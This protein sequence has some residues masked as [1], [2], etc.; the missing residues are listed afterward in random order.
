MLGTFI[1]WYGWFSFNFGTALLVPL[2]DVSANVGALA[3]TN[4]AIAAG[5]AATMSL[6]FNY[7]LLQRSTGSG[8]YDLQMAMNGCLAGSVSIT[9]GCAVYEPWA[10]LVTGLVAG[11]IYALGN[12]FIIRLRIDDAVDAIPVHLFAG[13]WGV[14]SVGFLASPTRQ[15]AAYGRAEHSGLLYEWSNGSFDATLLGV[16]FIGIFFIIG[17]VSTMLLPFFLWLD[18]M[19]WLRCD[20]LEEIVGLDTHEH[21]GLEHMTNQPETDDIKV[22]HFEAYKRRRQHKNAEILNKRM[23]QHNRQQSNDND[24]S[25][26]D[27]TDHNS[28]DIS[29]SRISKL[30]DTIKSFGSKL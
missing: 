3:A 17:W 16:Q 25:M 1:L 23:N 12:R 26:E 7:W 20:A 29:A 22:D 5:G 14:I 27:Q 19:K 11:M 4:T 13:S 2:T 30:S 18:Y 9:A 15:L 10:A 28:L 21:C 8:Y 24:H 6:L